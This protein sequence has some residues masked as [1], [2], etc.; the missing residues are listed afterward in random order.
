[1]SWLTARLHNN[2][3]GIPGR[4]QYTWDFV[5]GGSWFF[6]L[7]ASFQHTYCYA[8]HSH[9]LFSYLTHNTEVINLKLHN[10]VSLN[11]CNAAWPLP[12]C[13]VINQIKLIYWNCDLSHNYVDITSYYFMCTGIS[14]NMRKVCST[15]G[16]QLKYI[17]V[18]TAFK[19]L[20]FSPGL[21]SHNKCMYVHIHRG[22][23]LTYEKPTKLK[24]K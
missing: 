11:K 4:Q 23:S 2:Q 24:Y 5:E 17:G 20:I 3:S 21:F 19:Y 18:K 22:I 6:A 10:S 14:R 12:T 9:T 7:L 13:I 16:I 8:R 1:M 15:L